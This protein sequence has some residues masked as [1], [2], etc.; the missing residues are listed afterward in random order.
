MSEDDERQ[1]KNNGEKKQL[2]S[3]SDKTWAKTRYQSKK[4]NKTRE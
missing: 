3:M 4:Q 2:K 1:N